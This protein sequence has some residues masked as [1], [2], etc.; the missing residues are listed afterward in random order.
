MLIQ[1]RGCEAKEACKRTAEW[2][3]ANDLMLDKKKIATLPDAEKY[4]ITV[5][6]AKE[7]GVITPGLLSARLCTNYFE[8]AALIDQMEEHDVVAAYD[9]IGHTLLTSQR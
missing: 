1:K 4:K 3:D 6:L 8:A 5:E 9:G 7:F 2:D